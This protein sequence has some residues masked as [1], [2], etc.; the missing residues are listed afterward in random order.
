VEKGYAVNGKNRLLPVFLIGV[1]LKW[2]IGGFRRV[3]EKVLRVLKVL[4]FDGP[5]AR[6]FWY[7]R[8]A[9]MIIKS[10]LRD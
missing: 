10:A 3:V 1:P 9:A 8:F 6:G 4:K 7:R 5:L 2:G